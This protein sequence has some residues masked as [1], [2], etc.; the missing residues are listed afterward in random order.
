MRVLRRRS[1][2]HDHAIS[3]YHNSTSDNDVN[4]DHNIH[5]DVHDHHNRR[6]CQLL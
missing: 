4:V 6:T 2:A 3:D 1:A 5:N